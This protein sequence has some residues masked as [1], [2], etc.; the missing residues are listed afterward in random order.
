[1]LVVL[2]AALVAASCAEAAERSATPQLV[3]VETG[4]LRLDPGVISSF[5]A[6]RDVVVV[7]AREDD[8]ARTLQD[9]AA[10]PDN[11]TADVVVGLPDAVVQDR[12]DVPFAEIVVDGV[13]RLP[14]GLFDGVPPGAIPISIRDLCVL[15]DAE[16]VDAGDVEAP[17]SFADLIGDA[18]SGRLVIPD[19]ATTLEGRLLLDAIRQVAPD[20]A[21]PSWLDIAASFQRN[22]TVVAPTW[23]EGFD[24]QFISPARPD[25]PP[26]VWG[27]AG[28]PAAMVA[29]EP[30]L[31]AAPTLGVVSTT[32]IRSTGLAVVPVAA[33]QPT[34]ATQF[35]AHLLT[36]EV[37]VTL[38]DAVGSLPARR[39]V[40][41]PAAW[42][43]FALRING[44]LRPTP[45]PVDEPPLTSVWTAL[46]DGTLSPDT[47]PSAEGTEGEP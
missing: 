20:E 38:V 35:V 18:W 25:G 9:L 41:L 4:G 31:P 22:G 16:T 13:E 30:E 17:R 12:P 36:P 21:T 42:T 45:R 34:L 24:T 3:V 28:M 5:E 29:F 23:R 44:P 19:P 46:L 11:P 10:A 14:E 1:M 43:R 37:Q 15:Y 33:G 6:D 27:A 32:C 2:V 8:P 39:D 7:V 26:L 47:D 40:P